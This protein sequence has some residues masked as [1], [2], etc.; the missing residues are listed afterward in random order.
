[1]KTA[2]RSAPV[3]IEGPAESIPLG[4]VRP[5]ETPGGYF[6]NTGTVVG[7]LQVILVRVSLPHF[8]FLFTETPYKFTDEQC[9][10]KNVGVEFEMIIALRPHCHITEVIISRPAVD[11]YGSFHVIHDIDTAATRWDVVSLRTENQ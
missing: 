5:I 2:L 3:C 11:I 6:P 10:A 9:R 4:L 1:M 8:D 7:A